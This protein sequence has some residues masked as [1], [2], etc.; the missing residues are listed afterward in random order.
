LLIN[1]LGLAASIVVLPQI[2]LEDQRTLRPSTILVLYFF[3]S[4]LLDLWDLWTVWPIHSRNQ[5]YVI[6]RTLLACTK[7]LL[8]IL[9]SAGKDKYFPSKYK[10]LPP[11]SFSGIVNRTLFWWLN[12]L[13]FVS[14]KRRISTDDLYKLDEELDSKLLGRR[15]LEAW[16]ERGMCENRVMI[17]LRVILIYQEHLHGG[18]VLSCQSWTALNGR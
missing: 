14:T 9:E 8:L 5:S 13:F 11:E 10:D 2:Y 6:E 3:A 4:L 15:L 17:S 18:L 1:F 16:S 7:T 12:P